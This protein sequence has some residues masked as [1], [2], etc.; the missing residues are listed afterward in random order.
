MTPADNRCPAYLHVFAA[1]AA[2]L[3]ALLAGCAAP[4]S[5]RAAENG[6]WAGLR[7]AVAR[8]RNTGALDERKVRELAQAVAEHEIRASSGESARA[9]IDEAQ[10]CALALTD[11]LEQR[12]NGSGDDS[13]A[14]AL[15]LL[16]AR[17]PGSTNGEYLWKRH[18]EDPNPLWRAVAARAQIGIPRGAM[19]RKSYVDS[20][21]RVRLAAL[22]AALD[23]SDPADAGPL[24]EAARLDPNPLAQSLAAR[25]VGGIGSSRVVVGLRDLYVS[26]DEALRQSIVDGWARPAAAKAGGM[27]ELENTAT[28]GR[29]SPAVEAAARLL[30]FGGAQASLGTVV[31]LRAMNDGLARD[32]VLAIRAA[33]I[34]DA[35]VVVA[36]ERLDRGG[37]QTVRAAALARLTEIP[38]SRDRA[39]GELRAMAER[40]LPVALTAL[41]TARDRWA[42]KM[43]VHALTAPRVDTRLAAAR[44]LSDLG[45]SSRAAEILGDPDPRVRMTLS[46][47]ILSARRP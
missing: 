4:M 38:G 16:D 37:D 40:G 12:A 36:L 45:E 32:R 31:I 26:A 22:R 25:A 42:T 15:A 13:A 27:R 30:T 23:S 1:A 41:A 10:P 28:S 46:C 33:P 8:E 39:I 9:R 44:A 20:D 5:R 29:G 7:A 14:A 3:M 2:W 43:L 18:G 47:A 19:R 11:T 21:E 17:S 34:A 6:D 35:R 24:L